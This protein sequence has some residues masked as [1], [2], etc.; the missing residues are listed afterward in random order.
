MK[1]QCRE[2]GTGLCDHGRDKNRCR[3]C[4]TGYCEHNRRKDWCK[5]CGTSSRKNPSDTKQ[6]T[7]SPSNDVIEF[8]SYYQ[9]EELCWH[10]FPNDICQDCEIQLL[11]N[12]IHEF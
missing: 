11:S 3:E 1:Y 8:L 2:C 6:V 12:N 10:G 9:P 7:E 5:D 4:G